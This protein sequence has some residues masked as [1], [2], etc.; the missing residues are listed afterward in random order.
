MARALRMSQDK[1]SRISIEMELPIINGFETC[2]ILVAYRFRI[3]Y[4][5]IDV[6][7]QHPGSGEQIFYSL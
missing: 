1:R 2:T 4:I 5:D 7:S 6:Q 3:C